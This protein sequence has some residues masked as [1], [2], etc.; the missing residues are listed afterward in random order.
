MG[1]TTLSGLGRRATKGND[2]ECGLRPRRYN[3]IPRTWPT[4]HEGHLLTHPSQASAYFLLLG[5]I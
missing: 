4:V 3:Y 1:W 2:G 5:Y